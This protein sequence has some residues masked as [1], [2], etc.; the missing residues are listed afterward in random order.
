MRVAPW[1][2]MTRSLSFSPE[3]ARSLVSVL[4]VAIAGCAVAEDG[5]DTSAAAISG[6]PSDELFAAFDVAEGNAFVPTAYEYPDQ[7]GRG[8]TRSRVSVKLNWKRNGETLAV[9]ETIKYTVSD[10]IVLNAVETRI[11]GTTKVTSMS[12]D[13][14]GA[15][16]PTSAHFR[17]SQAVL[18]DYLAAPES[19]FTPDAAAESKTSCDGVGRPGYMTRGVYQWKSIARNETYLA[20]DFDNDV[21]VLKHASGY[22]VFLRKVAGQLKAEAR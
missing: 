12:R 22:P 20:C 14:W 3:I 21:I 9:V 4:L 16:L 7:W 1:L 13:Q 17:F 6:S 15:W 8:E 5:P 19:E 11:A 18:S 2:P 10:D